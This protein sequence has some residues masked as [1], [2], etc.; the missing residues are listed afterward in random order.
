MFVQTNK[1]NDMEIYNLQNDLKVFGIQV[2]TFPMG[3]GEA[4]DKLI[5]MLPGGFDRSY[6]GISYMT[7]DGAMMYIAAAIEKREG[8]AEKYNCER[9]IIEKGEYMAITVNDWRSKTD[10]IKDIFYEIIK[11]SRIDKTSPAIEW[12]KD[13]KQMIC[14][15]KMN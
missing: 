2:K 9:Y 10:C 8:E 11:D 3:I 13:E 1:I 15:V 12:Y 5:K 14:M 4:F 7:N 6:Y